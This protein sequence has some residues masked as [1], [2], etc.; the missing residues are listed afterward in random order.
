ML[1]PSPLA[2]TPAPF[3]RWLQPHEHKRGIDWYSSTAMA[4]DVYADLFDTDLDAVVERLDSGSQGA[5]R[6]EK[7]S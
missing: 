1:R 2:R 6:D 3:G 5:S 7:G 4:L